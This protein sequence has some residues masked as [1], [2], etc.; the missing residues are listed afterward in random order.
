MIQSAHS[1]NRSAC[2]DRCMCVCVCFVSVSIQPVS[3]NFMKIIFKILFR[4]IREHT[5]REWQR[6]KSHTVNRRSKHQHER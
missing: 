1:Q 2:V 5:L 4:L 3:V 6:L